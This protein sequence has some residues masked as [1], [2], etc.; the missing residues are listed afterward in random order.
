MLP[1]IPAP[2]HRAE[3]RGKAAALGALD[4]EGEGILLSAGALLRAPAVHGAVLLHDASDQV[5]LVLV[6]AQ[7]RHHG[8][9]QCL[10]GGEQY[11]RAWEESTAGEESSRYD[12]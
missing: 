4:R 5:V 12:R 2:R 8:R 10:R 9:A 11:A 7:L 1:V 3:G 6:P